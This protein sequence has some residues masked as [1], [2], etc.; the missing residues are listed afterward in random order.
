MDTLADT[1]WHEFAVESEEHLQAVEP[2]LARADPQQSSAVDI[3]QLF[4]SFHSVKG[5]ARAMD[6]LG[7]EGVAHHAENILGLVRDG[8]VGLTPALADLLLQSVDALKR[9]RDVVAA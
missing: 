4:R 1:L 9:M 8:R 2:M 6:V 3:A 5:L 7:M